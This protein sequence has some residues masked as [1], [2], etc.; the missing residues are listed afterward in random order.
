MTLDMQPNLHGRIADLE[1]RIAELK[2]S[3]GQLEGR[4]ARVEQHLL[5]ALSP[6]EREEYAAL[7]AA[8]QPHG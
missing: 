3:A 2:V 7:I 1:L 8:S 6:A 5:G 4:I